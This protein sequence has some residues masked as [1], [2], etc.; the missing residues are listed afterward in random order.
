ML[1]NKTLHSCASSFF[2]FVADQKYF[3]SRTFS[4]NMLC[5]RFCF[6]VQH[7]GSSHKKIS[8]AL[9]II[10]YCFD[11]PPHFSRSQPSITPSSLGTFSA[12]SVADFLLC[13]CFCL[14]KIVIEL[15]PVLILN[16]GVFVS[17]QGHI[18]VQTA[19]IYLNCSPIGYQ[20]YFLRNF[21]LSPLPPPPHPLPKKIRKRFSISLF[22]FHLIMTFWKRRDVELC[23]TIFYGR[24]LLSNVIS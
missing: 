2:F 16:F 14:E 9:G 5:K 24:F 23:F 4:I 10:S 7:A 20:I 19:L 22:Y 17:S 3:S 12:R 1:Y 8:I 18:S 15:Q 13:F 6:R 21:L 11:S